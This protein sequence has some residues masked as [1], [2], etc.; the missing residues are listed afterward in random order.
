VGSSNNLACEQLSIYIGRSLT[1]MLA[2]DMKKKFT[3]ILFVALFSIPQLSYA[4]DYLGSWTLDWSQVM[5]S[6]KNE[7]AKVSG[8]LHSIN[9]KSEKNPVWVITS[10]S[11]KVYQSGEM[12]SA[13]E[14]K[15]TRDDRFEII[16]DKKNEKRI[17][18]IE[19]V[20]SDKIKMKTRNS[21]SEIYLRKI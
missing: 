8:D 20:E 21:D 5:E 7:S 16:D 13:A 19:E 3:P 4:Q 14:I 9:K 17:H 15:W 12:I 6:S 11:L 1:K 2:T 18:Y 10:D